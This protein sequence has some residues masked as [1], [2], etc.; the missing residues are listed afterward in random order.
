MNLTFWRISG[1]QGK[2]TGSFAPTCNQLL[3]QALQTHVQSVSSGLYFLPLQLRD[4][5]G[6]KNCSLHDLIE[7]K[8]SL[9]NIIQSMCVSPH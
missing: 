6:L 4:E 5:S 9:G 7:I 2:A 3:N 8:V 1:R